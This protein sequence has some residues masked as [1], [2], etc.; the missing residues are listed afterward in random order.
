MK[1]KIKKII[2]LT[3]IFIQIIIISSSCYAI[4]TGEEVPIYTTKKIEEVKMNYYGKDLIPF[5]TVYK[6][7]GMECP[8][9]CANYEYAGVSDERTYSVEVT[10]EYFDS[11]TS[12]NALGVW[13][14]IINGYPFKTASELNCTNDYEAYAATKQ[15]VW[16]MLYEGREFK[17]FSYTGEEGK[18][19][20][21]A[22]VDIV[23]TAK[24]SEQTELEIT[25]DTKESEWKLDETNNTMVKDII[26]NCNVPIYS[27]NVE[28]SKTIPKG[29]ILKKL[30][31]N[32]FTKQKKIQIVIPIEN[33]TTNGNF[34]LN[35]QAKIPSTDLFYGKAPADDLQNY[36]MTSGKIM[37]LAKTTNYFENKTEL[38]ITKKD[39]EENKLEGVKFNILDENKNVV[40]EKIE[41]NKEGKIEIQHIIPGI[42]YIQEVETI[43]GYKLNEDLIQIEI[44]YDEIKKINVLNEK[45]PEK[46]KE[47]PPKLP[48]TG[49]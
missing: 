14:A 34:E 9:Y 11:G 44:G 15:A 12:R 26:V 29:T 30:Y 31:N 41:T 24:K 49:F 32:S 25:V 33:L 16:C 22:M 6:D 4:T 37:A 48:R 42:Y 3:Y 39:I 21:N 8:V 10:G 28:L 5:Y 19:V 1:Q 17:Y 46:P 35:I 47:E 43:D 36:V 40:Y 18:R 7:D 13:R 38:E 45:I 2:L 20:Y 27:L 23:T